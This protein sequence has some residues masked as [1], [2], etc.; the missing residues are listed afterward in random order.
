MVNLNITWSEAFGRLYGGA[1]NKEPFR[2][3]TIREICGMSP[4]ELTKLRG[5]GGNV[6]REISRTLETNGLRLGMT[7]EEIQRLI[8][9][10]FGRFIELHLNGSPCVINTDHVACI[11][12]NSGKTEIFFSNGQS[13]IYDETYESVKEVLKWQ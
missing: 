8:P 12:G 7:E 1:E 13:E 5:I 10:K 2:D 3:M 11:M 9:K 4:N 6:V